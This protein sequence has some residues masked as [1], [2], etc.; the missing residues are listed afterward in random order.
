MST[1]IASTSCVPME[2]SEAETLFNALKSCGILHGG[3]INPSKIAMGLE[4]EEARKESIELKSHLGSVRNQVGKLLTKIG[5][6]LNFQIKADMKY[7]FLRN[8]KILTVCWIIQIVIDIH[9]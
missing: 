2:I 4:Y 5:I 8:K 6:Q 9:F 7:N 1:G 3:N